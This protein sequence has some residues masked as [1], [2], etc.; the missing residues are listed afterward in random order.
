VRLFLLTDDVEEFLVAAENRD[1]VFKVI[2][3]EVGS[4]QADELAMSHLHEY[5]DDFE[6]VPGKRADGVAARGR[7]VIEYNLIDMK[8]NA[9]RIKK[10]PKGCL[11]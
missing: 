7:G 6:L 5:P 8:K 2:E 3:E 10:P 1:D 9:P 11:P 4:E